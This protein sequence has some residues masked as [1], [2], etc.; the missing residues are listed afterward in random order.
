MFLLRGSWVVIGRVI[1]RA[2]ILI[3]HI[4][5]LRTPLITIHEPPSNGFKRSLPHLLHAARHSG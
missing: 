4:R 3:A 2:T 1:S 5:G